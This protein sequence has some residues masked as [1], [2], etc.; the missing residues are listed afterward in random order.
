[1][2]KIFHFILML[3][4]LTSCIESHK[5]ETKLQLKT[6]RIQIA[7]G[8]TLDYSSYVLGDHIQNVQ[9]ETIDTSQRGTYDVV[10]KLGEQQQ[11]LTVDIVRMYDHGIFH[12]ED[13]KPTIVN[14]PDDVTT[15]VNKIHQLPENY[16][17]QDLVDVIDSH[18]QLRKEAADAYKEFYLAAKEKGIKCYAI[19]GYRTHETQTLYW[20]R[21]KA[22]KGDE[23]ASEYSAYPGRSEH[24]LGLAIDVS[25]RIDGDR[26]TEEVAKQPIGQFIESDA[27]RYGFILR[28]PKDKVSITNYGYEP[29]HM[30]Y[31]GIDLATKLHQ[32]GL[33]LEEYKEGVNS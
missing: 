27:Y 9:W 17:P 28:Y 30:R 15:L 26:L 20:Q 18:Q 11:V 12:P 7:Q 2:N 33:T 23:Y 4:L 31:V 14:N 25:Y 8:E 10:Y 1:M 32:S 16:V 19:S 24:Q 6:S 13:V 3:F 29:W 5:Q 21:Q 22:I